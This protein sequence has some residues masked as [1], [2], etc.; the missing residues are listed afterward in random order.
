MLSLSQPG[1]LCFWHVLF[2]PPKFSCCVSEWRVCG[3]LD[4]RCL[5][6][7]LTSEKSNSVLS[8][9]SHSHC[10]GGWVFPGGCLSDRLLWGVPFFRNS[11]AWGSEICT[12]ECV[13]TWVRMRI[14]PVIIGKALRSLIAPQRNTGAAWGT[15][16]PV[17]SSWV[18]GKWHLTSSSCIKYSHSP[19]K[20]SSVLVFLRFSRVVL[21]VSA[22]K[23]AL[24]GLPPSLQ[25]GTSPADSRAAA[26]P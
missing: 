26:L 5:L 9:S 10:Q 18:Q 19:Y 12:Y 23:S 7:A 20:S 25:P 16:G 22:K 21:A 11:A 15:K 8:V 2:L 24:H 17:Q 14:T 4:R 13:N 6:L 3:C 1:P